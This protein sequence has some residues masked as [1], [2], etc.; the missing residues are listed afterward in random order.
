V[1]GKSMDVFAL[2]DS[3]VG[4]YRKFATSFTTIHTNDI[5]Q[6]EAVYAQGRFWPD[7]LI[8]INPSYKGGTKL[9]TLIAGG[10]LDPCTAEIFRD[11]DGPFS[12]DKHQEQAIAL[13]AQG[14]SYAL[15]PT[16]DPASRSASS[17]RS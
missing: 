17:S 13:A 11:G 15:R 9:E 10:A 3:V 16:P 1:S 12:L 5:R 14:E 8:Q 7:P 6:V 4:E 2:R